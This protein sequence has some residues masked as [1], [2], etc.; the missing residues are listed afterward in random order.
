MA[1]GIPWG[2]SNV[3]PIYEEGLPYVWEDFSYL[4]AGVFYFLHPNAG[5]PERHCCPPTAW[6]GHCG[7]GAQT[8]GDDF[9]PVATTTGL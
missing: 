3:P 1:S 5:S 9:P 8:D 6:G 7:A 4:L 2:S